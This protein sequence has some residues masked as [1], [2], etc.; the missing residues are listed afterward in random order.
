LCGSANCLD[1]DLCRQCVL[2]LPAAEPGQHCGTP[3]F[4]VV[5]S[6]WRYDYPVDRLIRALKFHGDRSVARTFGDLLA[7]RRA[8]LAAPLPQLVVPVPLHP[9]RLRQ[10]GFNQA[11]E[12]ARHVATVL[13]LQR[14]P[15]ALLRSRDTP[16]QSRLPAAERRQNLVDAFRVAAAARAG[17]AG[18]SI[19]L[20][21]DVMTTGSTARAAAASLLEAGAM[22]VELWTLARAE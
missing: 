14:V 12:I 9:A 2:D 6:P 22:Q 13:Q 21:D 1:V 17:L 10:R 11:D 5:F 7:R 15:H 20:I 16:A 19:A 8:A 3:P 18:R 4:T